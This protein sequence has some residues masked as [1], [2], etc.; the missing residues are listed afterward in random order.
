MEQNIKYSN[1][2]TIPVCFL[3]PKTEDKINVIAKLRSH[4]HIDDPD[5]IASLPEDIFERLKVDIKDPL[6]IVKIEPSDPWENSLTRAVYLNVKIGDDIYSGLVAIGADFYVYKCFVDNLPADYRLEHKYLV[7]KPTKVFLSHC[8][9]DKGF[10][11]NL[12]ELLL[13]HDIPVW[14]DEAE[15]K[16][17]ESLIQK[18]REGID[19]VDYVLAVISKNSINSEWVKREIDVAMNLEIE[20][21]TIKVMPILIDGSDLPGFLKGKLYVKFDNGLI[22]EKHFF[23]LIKSIKD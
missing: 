4:Y 21:K 17:G 16:V 7:L 15:I 11:N 5:I 19:N 9:K 22:D 2:P 8:H 10:V 23:K 18:I 1:I 12:A 14:I 3:N 13:S 6:N 20:N